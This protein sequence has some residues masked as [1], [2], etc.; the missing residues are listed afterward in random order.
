MMLVERPD[1]DPI[2]KYVPPSAAQAA[3]NANTAQASGAQAQAQINRDKS[4]LR[5]A[6]DQQASDERQQSTGSGSY[7]AAVGSEIANLASEVSA[8]EAKLAFENAWLNQA[9]SDLKQAQA[10][11]AAANAQQVV[12]QQTSQA[13]TNYG[14]A[15]TH[16]P[17]APDL[18]TATS[19]LQNA[20]FNEEVLLFEQNE[21][22]QYAV[23]GSVQWQQDAQS[24][25]SEQNA[26]ALQ[27]VRDEVAAQHIGELQS[28]GLDLQHFG[29]QLW[30]G[31]NVAKAQVHDPQ[32]ALDG[33][34]VAPT[35][36]Q[37]AQGEQA[38]ANSLSKSLKDLS[39]ATAN[40]A[41][42]S[43]GIDPTLGRQ[44]LLAN[45]YVSGL[46]QQITQTMQEISGSPTG[47]E[48]DGVTFLYRM[49]NTSGIDPQL[50]TMIIGAAAPTLKEYLQ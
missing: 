45:G 38:A 43:D 29:A 6:K 14:K 27:T 25:L 20:T 12:S 17:G 1:R 50:A 21:R 10:D 41:A 16:A 46:G 36:Q 5:K 9:K 13:I 19:N 8:L 34:G 4:D 24:L 44:A 32:T 7:P 30:A 33:N 37:K 11:F 39:A 49:V 18:R 2:P 23:P 3:Q 28:K 47:S 42:N 40:G 26:N 31:E 22:V 15:V 48:A 35:L